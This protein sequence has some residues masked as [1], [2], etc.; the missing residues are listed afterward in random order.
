VD[1]V[2]LIPRAIDLARRFADGLHDER[3]G[4]V[5]TRLADQSSCELRG[6]VRV[7]AAWYAASSCSGRGAR[8]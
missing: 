3:D 7:G 8:R 6:A 4:I 5:Y 2:D 1:A